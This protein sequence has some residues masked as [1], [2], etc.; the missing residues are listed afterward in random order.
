MSRTIRQRLLSAAIVAM[1]GLVI[2][3]LHTN[4]GVTRDDEH[5]QVRQMVDP[6]ILPVV[7]SYE[8]EPPAIEKTEPEPVH[9]EPALTEVPAAQEPPAP[10]QKEQ[11]NTPTPAPQPAPVVTAET[12]GT[13][14][15]INLSETDAG[16]SITVR[17]NRPIGD[18]TYMNLSN[19]HR[20]V[21]DLREKWA[22]KTRNVV[23]PEAGPV[24]HIVVG[25]HPDRLR[26]VVHFRTPP[27]GKLAPEFERTG[28]SLTVTVPLP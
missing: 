5:S 2:F 6:T 1:A 24:K 4:V 17:A 18:T 10:I 28:N 13:I 15:A 7:P 20:L 9:Q 23:R 22:L 19:P 26:L 12:L 14:T 3:V 16:F 25:T 8:T 21:I 27:V 11:E